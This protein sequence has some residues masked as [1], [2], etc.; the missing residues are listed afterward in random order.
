MLCQRCKKKPTCIEPCR[1]LENHLKKFSRYLRELPCAEYTLEYLDLR[2]PATWQTLS[3]YYHNDSV[4]FPF[5]TKLQ[6]KC[7]HMFYF[8]GLTYN[9]IAMRVRKSKTVIK[10]QLQRGK[11]KIRSIFT[12][13]KGI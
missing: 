12:I 4:S 3:N 13:S 11:C 2:S 8:E 1:N 10:G 9:Q 7:L 5:L 6:N